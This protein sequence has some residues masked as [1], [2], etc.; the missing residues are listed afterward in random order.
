MSNNA[1]FDTGILFATMDDDGPV[2]AF[3]VRPAIVVLVPIAAGQPLVEGHLRAFTNDER[4]WS[5]KSESVI[6][7]GM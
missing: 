2:E 5:R 1:P 4:R 3:G 6:S 7:L